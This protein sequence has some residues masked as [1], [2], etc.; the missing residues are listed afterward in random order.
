MDKTILLASEDRWVIHS[1]EE[2][3]RKDGYAV[4]IATS[5]DE[6]VSKATEHHYFRCIMDLRLGSSGSADIA[7][8][9]QVYQLINQ[10]PKAGQHPFLGY[11]PHLET[12][13]VARELGI[14]AYSSLLHS[15]IL[16]F[17]K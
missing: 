8:A 10:Q 5:T 7:S 13:I 15:N 9:I 3:C 4:D 14:R 2:L 1:L 11:S 16:H 12:V 17:L 6:A